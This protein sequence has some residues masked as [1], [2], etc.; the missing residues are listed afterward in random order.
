MIGKRGAIEAFDCIL[1]ISAFLGAT[2]LVLQMILVSADI[3]FRYFLNSPIR[4]ASEIAE[5]SMLY[6]TFLGT[7][8]LL[9]REGHVSVD[10]LAARLSERTLVGLRSLTSAVCCLIFAVLSWSGAKVTY[11]LWAKDVVTPTILELPRAGIVIIIPLGCFLL[12]VQFARR[13]I[14]AW[15]SRELPIE[16]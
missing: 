13:A 1:N 7:A 15:S 9:K 8:W 2:L 5:V 6:L 10:I 14:K 12:S 16:K 11:G 3:V 4:G